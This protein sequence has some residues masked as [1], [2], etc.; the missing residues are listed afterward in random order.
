MNP[1]NIAE[2]E[3]EI[4]NHYKYHPIDPKGEIRILIL[5]PP[6]SPDEAELHCE[7]TTAKFS[8]NPS[9]EAISYC[10]GSDV[11]PETLYLPSGTLAITENLA[12]G[13][14]RFRL[15]DQPRRLWADAVCINQ[16]DDEEKGYQVALMATIFRNAECVLVWLGESNEAIDAGI[17]LIR[18]LAHSA[19]KYGLQYDDNVVQRV[20]NLQPKMKHLKNGITAAL[21]Q[22]SVD[23]DFQSINAFVDQQWFKRLWVIQEY[24]LASRAE[25]HN[26][27]NIL[28]HEDLFLAMAIVFLISVL[29]NS[30]LE[31]ILEKLSLDGFAAASS[32]IFQRDLPPY[33]DLLNLAVIHTGHRCKLDQDRIYALL[34]LVS[35]GP[36]KHLEIN[37]SLS[38]EEVYTRLALAYFRENDLY[39]LHF[40]GTRRDHSPPSSS[41]NNEGPIQNVSVLPSW[42]PDW[43]ALILGS[44]FM[45]KRK[46]K[47][48]TKVAPRIHFDTS[49][50]QM[51]GIEGVRIDIIEDSI[52]AELDKSVDGIDLEG[53]DLQAMA[54]VTKFKATFAKKM[55]Q[56]EY[57]TGE[58]PSMAF[59]RCLLLDNKLRFTQGFLGEGLNAKVEL[60]MWCQRNWPLIDCNATTRASVDYDSA[61]L[62][63]ALEAA[64]GFDIISRLAEGRTFLVTKTGYIGMGPHNFKAGDVACVFNGATAP[65]IIRKVTRHS[66]FKGQQSIT[67]LGEIET[68]EIIGDCYVHGIMKNEVASSEW[69]EKKEIFWIV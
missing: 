43:R 8:D 37:Y 5:Q 27:G 44:D 59:A 34:A 62:K 40:L 17:G 13:L 57:P 25:I 18:E 63:G 11:F 20:R 65:C 52:P 42:V 24:T 46:L 55:E 1:L 41:E 23:L 49:Y 68:W 69:Q 21:I 48:G 12:S 67:G 30:I 64:T 36:A 26:G 10:W 14:R 15:H 53:G 7:I 47:A 38:V 22:L 3:T 51:I 28:S 66:S 32:T 6:S 45:A 33:Y 16:Q 31:T 60:Q 39:I 56:A 54:G 19:W 50:S 9:Y 58:D 4:P 61:Y 35:T 29:P 2:H